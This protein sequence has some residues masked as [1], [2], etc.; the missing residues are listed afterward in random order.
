[1]E[2]GVVWSSVMEKGSGKSNDRGF[3]WSGWSG[4]SFGHL[5]SGMY[6]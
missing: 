1:M 3:G 5:A 6:A 2:Y 4:W